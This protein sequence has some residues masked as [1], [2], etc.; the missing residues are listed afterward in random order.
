L[1]VL[2]NRVFR[3]AIYI[4]VDILAVGIGMGVPVL[5]ILLGFPVGWLLPTVLRLRGVLAPDHLKAI[6][7]AAILTSLVTFGITA[8]IW[9][10]TLQRLADPAGD[11]ANF[12]I[13]MI[14]F[15]PLPSFIGWIVLMVVISPFLQVLTT[16]FGCV[17][18]CALLPPR[19]EELPVA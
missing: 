17:A 12:G 9:V 13:P 3:V 11:I 19:A 4:A 5:A 1:F 7:R 16:V 8:L 10:P 15:T 18:R 14:L 6:L 2:T